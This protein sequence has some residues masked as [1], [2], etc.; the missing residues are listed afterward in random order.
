ML[1]KQVLNIGPEQV[2]ESISSESSPY[3]FRY[4]ARLALF[5]KSICS[6]NTFSLEGNFLAKLFL[7]A[8]Q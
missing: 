5:M 6:G 8:L 4:L 3:K 2:L 1:M 7:A